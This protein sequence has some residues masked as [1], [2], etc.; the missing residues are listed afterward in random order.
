MPKCRRDENAA[1]ADLGPSLR[2]PMGAFSLRP[3]AQIEFSRAHIHHAAPA[4]SWKYQVFQ[5]STPAGRSPGSAQWKS[6]APLHHHCC[7]HFP[8]LDLLGTLADRGTEGLEARPGG[9]GGAAAARLPPHPG[10]K[11]LQILG[12]G[13]FP[14]R[15]GLT[16]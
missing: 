10:G 16:H 2:N 6:A 8:P 13:W 12:S 1:F 15:T 11:A 9:V 14:R 7:R 4:L 3:R 5:S